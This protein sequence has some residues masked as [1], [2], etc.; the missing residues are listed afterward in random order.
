MEKDITVFG[1]SVEINAGG[2]GEKD[3]RLDISDVFIPDLLENIFD[4]TFDHQKVDL[5]FNVVTLHEVVE[6]ITEED[7]ETL[8]EMLKEEFE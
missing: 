6:N 8:Y 7:R 1:D 4:D 5:L 2:Y 3:I